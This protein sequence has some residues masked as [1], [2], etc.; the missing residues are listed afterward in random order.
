MK[1]KNPRLYGLLIDTDGRIRYAE[2]PIGKD[3]KWS[4]IK[5]I[6]KATVTKRI[7]AGGFNGTNRI[8]I[9]NYYG[10]PLAG[11]NERAMKLTGGKTKIYGPALLLRENSLG[12][13]SLMSESA[14]YKMKLEVERGW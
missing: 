8:L 7:S 2:I 9:Y 12:Y 10:T 4:T 14:S 1:N 6:L 3:E 11:I 5:S 13:P